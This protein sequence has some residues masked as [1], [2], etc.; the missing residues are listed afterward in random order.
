MKGKDSY[1]F[2]DLCNV[3]IMERKDTSQKKKLCRNM[4]VYKY[5]QTHNVRQR[6]SLSLTCFQITTANPM[7]ISSCHYNLKTNPKMFSFLATHEMFLSTN[8]LKDGSERIIC[9]L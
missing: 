2:C 4:S 8:T 7:H 6:G 3:Q 1:Y 9:S 5:V